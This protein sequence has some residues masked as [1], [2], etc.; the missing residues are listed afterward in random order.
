MAISMLK[1]TGFGARL[2][3]CWEPKVGRK[4][5]CFPLPTALRASDPA[6]RTNAG[7]VPLG[8]TQL[9]ASCS[10]SF[11]SLGQVVFTL[12]DCHV[13]RQHPVNNHLHYSSLWGAI[14]NPRPIAVKLVDQKRPPLYPR[15][16]IVKRGKDM[17]LL[18]PPMEK[19]CDQSDRLAKAKKKP[20]SGWKL[21]LLKGKSVQCARVWL[22]ST[23]CLRFE[24]NPPKQDFTFSS[25]CARAMCN[26]FPEEASQ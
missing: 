16:S 12:L 24:K 8:C 7:S 15:T 20:A 17:I 4:A 19:S 14:W 21:G 25:A 18:T 1:S 10:G 5:R 6:R 9:L 23:I 22:Y 2:A 13:A 3:A 26:A 11:L